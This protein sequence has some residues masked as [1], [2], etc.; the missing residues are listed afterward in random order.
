MKLWKLTENIKKTKQ[1]AIKKLKKLLRIILTVRAMVNECS[2]LK[3]G[4]LP[5][6]IVK[7]SKIA[8]KMVLISTP[9]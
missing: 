8:R 5:I 2:W 3:F 6:M 1:Y 9:S 7:S 4:P